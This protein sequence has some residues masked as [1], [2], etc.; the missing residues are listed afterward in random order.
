MEKDKDIDL[1]NLG[2]RI[3]EI[4]VKMGMTQAELAQSS[5]IACNYIA[6]LERGE[7]NP[8]YKVLLKVAGGCGISLCELIK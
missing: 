3:R 8:T 2:Q 7:R 6:M 5:G 1:I 4:R